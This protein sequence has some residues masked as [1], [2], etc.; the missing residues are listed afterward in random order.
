MQTL[1]FLLL[2]L[3]SCLPPC[4]DGIG[5]ASR[6]PATTIWGISIVNNV[7]TSLTLIGT[8]EFG[9]LFQINAMLTVRMLAFVSKFHVS[10]G[11]FPAAF[12]YAMFIA[13]IFETTL[14]FSST[15]GA[16]VNRHIGSWPVIFLNKWYARPCWVSGLL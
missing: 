15:L 8:D 1:N 11:H 9:K 16:V 6:S 14:R 7:C 4:S 5:D 10:F 3:W 12:L 2:R 13:W